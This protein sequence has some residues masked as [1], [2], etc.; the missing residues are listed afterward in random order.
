MISLE[1]FQ[2]S[3]FWGSKNITLDFHSK[4]V[5]LTGHNGSGKST[6]LEILHDS[7]SLMHD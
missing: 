5:I 7:F 6:I 3:N 1:K 4:F 2:I